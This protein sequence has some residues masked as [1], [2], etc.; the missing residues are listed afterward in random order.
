MPQFR[1]LLFI[2]ISLTTAAAALWGA[3]ADW[4]V[5]GA[6]PRALTLARAAAV[7]ITGLAGLSWGVRVLLRALRQRDDRQRGEY[8]RREAVLIRMAE[9]TPPTVP[10]PRP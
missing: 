6:E 5:A 8:R 7:A 1:L 4:T 2:S 9:R 3:A 10:L